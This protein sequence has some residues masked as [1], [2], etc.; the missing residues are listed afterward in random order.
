MTLKRTISLSFDTVY[1]EQ[2]RLKV[3]VYEFE[4]NVDVSCTGRAWLK[5]YA[6]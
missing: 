6:R 5:V 2:L 4:I 1:T 3:V